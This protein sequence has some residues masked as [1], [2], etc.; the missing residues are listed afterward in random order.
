MSRKRGASIQVRSANGHHAYIV[1]FREQVG[2]ETVQR[3]RSFAKRSEAEVF[4]RQVAADLALFAA[5]KHLYSDERQA[6]RIDLAISEYRDHLDDRKRKPDSPHPVFCWKI[7]RKYA[8]QYSLKTTEDVTPQM[9]KA[10]SD[11]HRALGQSCSRAAMIRLVKSFCVWAQERYRI[12]PEVLKFKIPEH[13][14]AETPHWNDQ[15]TAQII[16]ELMRPLPESATLPAT[17]GSPEWR[18][19]IRERHAFQRRQCAI[20]LIRTQLLWAVRPKEC[21]L[22]LV[23]D[24]NA[25]ERKLTIPAPVAKNGH[26]RSFII[27]QETARCIDIHIDGRKATDRLFVTS[28]GYRWGIHNQ[29]KFMRALLKRLGLPGYLYSSRHTAATRIC[30]DARGNLPVI[31]RITGHRTLSQLQKYLHSDEDA[32]RGIA[33]TV[34]L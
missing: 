29:G 1:R 9:L 8:T 15:M 12:D 20:P 3:S 33:D 25:T 24:W 23:K 34:S 2:G 16:A 13:K 30:R 31:M 17:R 10:I 14:A 21:S 4:Q 5:G 22:L 28:N 6:G 19:K 27:D 32:Q 7:L 26:A 18:D 11:H